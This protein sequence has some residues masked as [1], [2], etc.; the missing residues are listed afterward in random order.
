MHAALQIDEVV[1]HVAD[2]VGPEDPSTLLHMSLACR[3]FFDP[4]MNA[5]WRVLR[6][7]ECLMRVLPER[8]RGSAE[9]DGVVTFNLVMP[10]SEAEWQRFAGYAQ[11][12]RVLECPPQAAWLAGWVVVRSS[13][14]GPV[15]DDFP[16]GPLFPN[17]HTLSSQWGPPCDQ[18]A[19]LLRPPLRYLHLEAVNEDSIETIIDALTACAETLETIFIHASSYLED[20][21]RL[22]H[23]LT[24]ALLKFK[25]LSSLDSNLPFPDAMIHL[26]TLS[27]L[28]EL[29]LH[30]I[31]NIPTTDLPFL[32]LEELALRVG[33]RAEHALVPFLQKLG[34]PAL[35][36]LNITRGFRSNWDSPDFR[37]PPATYVH[38]LLSEV[39]RFCRL[40][41]F[42][43]DSPL[44]DSPPED[45]HIL[46]GHMLTPLSSLR[47]LETLDLRVLP[48][49]LTLGDTES[50]A[51]AWPH[52]RYLR[53]AD[54]AFR[55]GATRLRLLEVDAL[56]PFA[57][58]CP[59]LDVLTLPLRI[60]EAAPDVVMGA[61]PPPSQV[62]AL[63]VVD[64]RPGVSDAAVELLARVFPRARVDCHCN[65][66]HPTRELNRRKDSWD[67]VGRP[68]Q[69][70]M[71]RI[72]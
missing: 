39:S 55:G 37:R 13:Y 56:L 72:S 60:S 27:T 30:D 70:G 31:Q 59:Q 43:L 49:H 40:R 9:V 24:N 16:G 58:L 20:S 64:V 52:M 12:V 19:L 26:S 7:P 47:A 41:T 5:L 28:R 69:S 35:Q 57:R 23:K 22:A 51:R 61:L 54:E 6:D 66:P 68:L 17:L 29:H 25:K 11:R 2:N 10:P 3:A 4:A 32:I 1:Q 45:E 67:V 21:G 63:C 8:T 50:L 53:V 71:S 33:V 14:W 38:T 44:T 65:D 48:V 34:A 62:T 18:H 46:S 15:M 36:M 42:T